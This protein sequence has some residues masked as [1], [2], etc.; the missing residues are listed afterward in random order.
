MTIYYEAGIPAT[1]IPVQVLGWVP[2][3]AHDLTGLYNV[4]IR[5]KRTTTAHSAGEVLHV[6][7]RAVVVKAGIRD[8][9]MRVRQA[10]LP[11][12]TDANTLQARV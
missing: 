1:L 5:V 7:A 10:P 6:P 8:S 12:R 9:H 4:V 11:A 2:T 3:P